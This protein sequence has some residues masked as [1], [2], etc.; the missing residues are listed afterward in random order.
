[1]KIVILTRDNKMS[2][3]LVNRLPAAHQYYVICEGRNFSRLFFKKFRYFLRKFSVVRGFFEFM[4]FI[5]ELPY[6]F[7]EMGKLADYLDQRM[8]DARYRQC[9]KIFSISTVNNPDIIPIINEIDPRLIIVMGTDIIQENIIR[10]LSREN[11]Y[12]VNCHSGITPEYR[13]A[14]AEFYCVLNDEIDKVGNTIHYVDKGVDTG[15][16]IMQRRISLLSKEDLDNKYNYMYLTFKNLQLLIEMLK[17]FVGNVMDNT[18]VESR[19]SAQK[20]RLYSTPRVR[21]YRLYYQIL[22]RHAARLE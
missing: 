18:V 3:F 11:R 13:G 17:E 22:Q 6:I 19:P 2:Q 1:M 16:I 20:G 4:G 7:R 8:P 21:D 10:G 9:E 14:K 12:F 5:F 15:G